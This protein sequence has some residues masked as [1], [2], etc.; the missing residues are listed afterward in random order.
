ME[1]SLFFLMKV[2]GRNCERYSI[3]DLD[4]EAVYQTLPYFPSSIAPKCSI[5]CSVLGKQK[6]FA[7][8]R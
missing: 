7:V 3:H 5:C 1:K 2:S 6:D 8:K 4:V